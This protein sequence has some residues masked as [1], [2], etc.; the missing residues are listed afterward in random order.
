[1]SHTWKA[2][3]L[4]AVLG[5]CS[6]ENGAPQGGEDS[7]NGG[8]GGSGA[9]PETTD[10]LPLAGDDVTRGGGTADASEAGSDPDSS[11]AGAFTRFTDPSSGFSTD[12]VRDVDRE[13]V[14][15][16]ARLGAM[17]WAATG[18]AVSGWTTSSADLSWSRSGVAFRVRFGTE[19][20]ERRAY[21]TETGSGTICNLNILG[22]EQL[23][24]FGTNE[25]PP[26]D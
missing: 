19:Q 15:F 23:T 12:E 1:M 8:G 13:V 16:D 3:A 18:D 4:V 21:F 9:G 7:A 24:I 14:R 6:S 2:A 5:A 17:V 10:S 20:G 26:Q 25:P 11:A 22:P